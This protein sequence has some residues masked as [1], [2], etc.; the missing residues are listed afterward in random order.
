MVDDGSMMMYHRFRKD[1]G[2]PLS[3]PGH[4]PKERGVR[5]QLSESHHQVS[6]LLSHQSNK[7]LLHLT[8]LSI[9]EGLRNNKIAMIFHH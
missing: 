9:A 8:D 3:H 2:N 7:H 1:P 6:T 4:V 5:L